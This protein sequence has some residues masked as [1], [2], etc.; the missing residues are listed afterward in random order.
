MEEEKKKRKTKKDFETERGSC[1]GSG[2]YSSPFILKDR[3]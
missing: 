1:H 2:G 3:Y